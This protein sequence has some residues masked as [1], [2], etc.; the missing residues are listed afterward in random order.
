VAAACRLTRTAAPGEV[1]GDRAHAIQRSEIAG[2]KILQ[3]R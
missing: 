2:A 3:K 1:A